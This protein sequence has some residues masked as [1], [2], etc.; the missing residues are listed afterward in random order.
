MERRAR[1]VLFLCAGNSA[2]SMLADAILNDLSGASFFAFSAGSQP[3]GEVHPYAVWPGR[4][5]TAHWGIPDP[6]AEARSQLLCRPAFA[7][8]YDQLLSLIQVFAALSAEQ[9]ASD[10]LMLKVDHMGR[11]KILSG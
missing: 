6:A 4:P 1:K 8:A 10:P 9:V 5:I 11:E 2:R 3:K 7:R